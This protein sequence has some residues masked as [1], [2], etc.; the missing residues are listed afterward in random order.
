MLHTAPV[1]AVSERAWGRAGRRGA[2]RSLRGR[3]GAGE[4]RDESARSLRGRAGGR[5]GEAKHLYLLLN[6]NSIDSSRVVVAKPVE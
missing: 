2:A 1:R 6:I 5:A 3:R 4:R